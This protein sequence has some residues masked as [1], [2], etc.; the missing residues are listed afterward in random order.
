[1]RLETYKKYALFIWL[2][3]YVPVA[4][5]IVIIYILFDLSSTIQNWIAILSGFGFAIVAANCDKLLVPKI[6]D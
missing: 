6:L 3:L 1:M 5:L 4:L 2:G